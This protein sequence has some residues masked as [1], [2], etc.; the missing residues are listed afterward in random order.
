MDRVI[1][2]THDVILLMTAYQCILFAFL[3]VTM[4]G[5]KWLSNLLLALF[6]LQQAAIPLDILVSFGAQFRF[7]AL[8]FSPNLFYVFGFGY[9]LEAP[10]LLWYTRSLVY[11]NYRLKQSDILYLLPFV[12]YLMYQMFF[13]YSLDFSAKKQ[14]QEGY[15][16]FVAPHYMNYVTLFREIFRV[17]LGLMCLYEIRRYR[18]HLKR[19][20]SAIEKQDLSWL[21]ILVVGFTGLR[22][23]SVLVIALVILSVVYGVKTDFELMGLIGNYTTFVLVSLLIFFSLRHSS[24][25]DGLDESATEA[26]DDG[27]R[28]EGDPA[29]AERVRH[30]MAESKPYLTPALTLDRLAQQVS[31]SPRQLSTLINRQF[32][33]NFF[34]FINCYRVAEAKILL[35]D[36]SQSQRTVLDIMYDVGFNSKATFNTLFKKKVGMTPSEYRKSR[37][38]ENSDL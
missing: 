11:K 29:E 5:E 37:L 23:W 17:I 12:A 20:F 10:L 3:L 7:I 4:H 35:S 33:C 27:P 24:V 36:A 16:L 18:H 31:L 2:N 22:A 32:H 14:L 30:W 28:G 15:D 8:E 6:L 1:F 9:W 26:T 25:C 38:S 19:N 13:Y 34:E 21:T